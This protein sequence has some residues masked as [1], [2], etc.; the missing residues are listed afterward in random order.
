MLV[1]LSRRKIYFYISFSIISFYFSTH[2]AFGFD[3]IN[4]YNTYIWSNELLVSPYEPGF[5]YLMKVFSSNNITF[6]MF[7]FFISIFNFICLFVFCNRMQHKSFAFFCIFS[8]FGF[9]LYGEQVRQGIACSLLILGIA[10]HDIKSKKIYFYIVLAAF[11]HVSAL[12]F[13]ICKFLT[14]ENK[15]NFKK[16]VNILTFFVLLMIVILLFPNVISF[17]PYIGPKIS[18][19]SASYNVSVVNLFVALV[20]S[21]YTWLYLFMYVVLNFI[22]VKENDNKIY[23]SKLA[24]Y[25][26]LLSKTTPVLLRF[27]Y[28]LIPNLVIGIDDYM[29][30]KTKLG[31]IY[32]YKTILYLCILLT[33]SATMWNPTLLQATNIYL[34]IF[35]NNNID[36]VMSQKCTIAYKALYG[37]DLFPSCYK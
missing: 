30:R 4:Y 1:A 13:L 18:A 35:D 31:K 10:L 24:T 28:Y 8:F 32:A 6:G 16:K 9:Y 26:L 36:L 17:I 12:F 27:G 23:T 14:S 15:S 29:F 25:F 2:Y 37:Q 20:L 33:S 11:F 3:W 34:D 7:Y 5:F 21:K 19:Y 22:L